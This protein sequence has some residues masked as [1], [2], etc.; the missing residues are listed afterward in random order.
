MMR[1]KRNIVLGMG[2]LMLWAVFAPAQVYVSAPAP[3]RD[4]ASSATGSAA[5]ANAV[6][7]GVNSSGN[8]GG[9]VACDSSA[10]LNVTT[11][12]TTQIIA[13][14]AGKTI[15]VCGMLINSAGTT[16]VRL[17]QGNGTNCATAPVNMTPAFN[18]AA[19][20]NVA[21]GGG[22]GYVMKSTAGNAICVTNS[23]AIGTNTLITYT[24]F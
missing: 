2:A 8:V 21:F 4:Q 23:A 3:V 12:T 11:A 18:L 1:V 5:P 24:Q 13:L 7:M 9:M 22:L 20:T 14:V 6:Y 16:T 19:S 17:V 15:Y 10:Q